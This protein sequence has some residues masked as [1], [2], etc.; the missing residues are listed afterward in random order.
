MKHNK[1]INLHFKSKLLHFFKEIM[2]D[3]GLDKI[4]IQVVHYVF[5]S[6]KLK[7]KRRIRFIL[8]LIC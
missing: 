2:N 6:A 4:R 5:G 8:M 7:E 1:H 3:K